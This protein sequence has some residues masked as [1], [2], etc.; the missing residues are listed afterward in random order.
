MSAVRR[1]VTYADVAYHPLSQP[2][3][4]SVSARHEVELTDGRRVLLLDDRGWGSTG[5][6][7]AMSAEYI[8]E[9]TRTVVGPDSPP[10][11]R[12]QEDM[13]TL[14]WNSLQQTAQRQGVMVDA[15]E[16]RRLPHDVVISQQLLALI[17]GDEGTSSS[18]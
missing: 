6:W 12:S 1:L 5:L 3:E 13:E 2:G 17:G 15:D 10:A 18:G 7:A 4:V 14:H 8:R 9:N 11:G 16:L